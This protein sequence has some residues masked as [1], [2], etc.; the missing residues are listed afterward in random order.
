MQVVTVVRDFE[1]YNRFIKSNTGFDGAVFTAFDNRDDN[2]AIPVRYNSFLDGY[3]YSNPAWFVFCHEDFEPLELLCALL[4]GLSKDSLWGPVGCHRRHFLG[5]GYQ[6]YDG[7][8]KQ[9]SP[10]TGHVIGNPWPNTPT[11]KLTETFDCCCLIVHSSLVERYHL[12]FDP[13]LQFDLYI[14][15]FCANA[16]LHYGV[17]SRILRFAAAHHSENAATERLF[18]HLPYLEKK[19]PHNCFCGTCAYFGHQPLLMRWQNW[20]L[21]R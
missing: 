5:V 9:V 16:K 13:E 1:Q 7:A 11:G 2:Q 12:R 6:V 15:D 17:R 4:D 20:L 14:E 8:I 21:G 18:R 19:Y 10:T 3:D